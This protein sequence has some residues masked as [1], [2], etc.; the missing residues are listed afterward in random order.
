[1]LTRNPNTVALN[2]ALDLWRSTDQTTLTIGWKGSVIDAAAA[3][4]FC[5]PAWAASGTCEISKLYDQSFN[6][7]TGTL[8]S[9]DATVTPGWVIDTATATAGGSGCTPGT[10]TF[11]VA[12]GVG[13]AAT[14]SG[15]V[16]GG[17]TLTLGALTV[18]TSGSYATQPSTPN[19]PTGGGCGTPPTIT[20]TFQ[21]HAPLWTTNTV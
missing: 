4:A 10:Q 18:A 21:Q 15:T 3:D 12:G 5:V 7:S 19:S 13:T 20:L 11:T 6:I 2:K 17:G 14:V 16:S 1:L 9:N 8:N